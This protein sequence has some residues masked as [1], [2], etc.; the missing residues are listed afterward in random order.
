M[1]KYV[2]VI[3]Y[4]ASTLCAAAT[5][6]TAQAGQALMEG[7]QAAVDFSLSLAGG[8]CLWSAVSEL[9]ARCGGTELLSRLLRPLLK[10]LFPR[11]AGD[12]ETMSA[13]SENLSANVLGLGNAATPAGIRA[14]K[15][16]AGRNEHNELCM[17]V[18]LNSASVQLIPSTMAALRQ[19]AGA[20]SAFDIIPAVWFASAASLAAG[21]LAA[22]MLRRLWP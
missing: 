19:S 16:M 11:S 8:I 10:W 21:L 20:A 2:L 12:R 14:A 13:L 1:M 7:A 4:C 22:A 6:R 3:L 17:L 9:M 15:R 5:G 18:L